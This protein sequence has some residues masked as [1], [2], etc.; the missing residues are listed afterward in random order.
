MNADRGARWR[1][2]PAIRLS[3]LVHAAAVDMVPIRPELWPWAL[4]VVAGNHLLLV[5][6]SLFPRGR[7]VGPNLTR[8]PAATHRAGSVPPGTARHPTPVTR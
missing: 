8:L 1:P 2:A 7:L 5:I 3:L 4:G 6:A